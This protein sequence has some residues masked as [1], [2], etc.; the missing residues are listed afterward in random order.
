MQTQCS[1]VK[2]SV[3]SDEET[4]EVVQRSEKNLSLLT[5][6]EKLVE[7]AEFFKALGDETRIQIIGMLSVEELCM[8][9]IVSGLQIPTSTISH[10]LKLL[11]RGKVIQSRKAGRYTVFSLDKEKVLAYLR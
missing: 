6:E 7:T 11:E 5:N 8:C 3:K 1:L 4:K 10:H 2:H 9:E